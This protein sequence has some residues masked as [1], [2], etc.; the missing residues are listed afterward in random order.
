[1]LVEDEATLRAALFE[2]LDSAGYTVSAARNGA[3]A[4][5][6]FADLGAIDVVV[7]DIVVR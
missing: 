5:K 1:M 2:H 6:M 3:E 4:L 7:T